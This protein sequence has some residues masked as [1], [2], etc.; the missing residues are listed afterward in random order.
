KTPPPAPNAKPA[1]APAPTG[2]FNS[3]PLN[4]RMTGD[5]LLIASKCTFNAIGQTFEVQLVATG[6]FIKSENHIVFHPEQIYL[7]C[8]PLHKLPVIGGWLITRIHSMQKVPEELSAAWEKVTS[9]SVEN[10]LL[11]ISTVP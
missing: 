11:Q 6:R 3:S 10:G 7:G 9:A 5:Q 4:F 8:C 1:P 2:F